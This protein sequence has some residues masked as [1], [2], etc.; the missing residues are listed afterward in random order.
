MNPITLSEM[1]STVCFGLP[2][3][4]RKLSADLSLG[5][6]PFPQCKSA[7]AAARIKWNRINAEFRHAGVRRSVRISKHFHKIFLMRVQK[8]LI[9]STSPEGGVGGALI[10]QRISISAPPREKDAAWAP[11]GYHANLADQCGIAAR[12]KWKCDTAFVVRPPDAVWSVD[13]SDSGGW[14]L[15]RGD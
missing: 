10:L 12:V 1:M 13:M 7:T 14:G 3:G 6:I 11:L 4:I 15:A 5:G 2:R 8:Q 9:K